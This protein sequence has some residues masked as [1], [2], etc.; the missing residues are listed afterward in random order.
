MLEKHSAHNE[1]HWR[2]VF[3]QGHLTLASSRSSEVVKDP[4]LREN[5]IVVRSMRR[6][7]G[8]IHREQS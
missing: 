3:D 8:E 2:E 5:D 7:K 4:Q 1:S 6:R